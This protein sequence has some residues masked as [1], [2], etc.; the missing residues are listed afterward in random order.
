MP[1][2]SAAGLGDAPDGT[3]LVGGDFGLYQLRGSRFEKLKGNFK[4]VSW[5]QGIQAD[6][7]GHTYIGTDTGLVVL[8]A[9]ADKSGF[10]VQAIPQPVSVTRTGAFGVLVDG[11]TVWYGCGLELCRINSQGTTVLGRQ[12][13]LPEY[14]CSTIQKDGD[15]NLWLRKGKLGV[16]E[17]PAGQTKFR[18]P[19]SPVLVEAFGGIAS[20]DADGR[21]LLPSAEGLLIRDKDGWQKV[22]RSVGL[23]G[24]VYSVLEDRQHSLWIGLAG[25]GLVQWRGYR[26]W[27][28]YSTASGLGNDLVYEVLARPDGSMWAGTEGGLYVGRQRDLKMVWSRIASF[29]ESAVHSLQLAPDGDLWV[30]TEARGAARM[31]SLDHSV[32]WFGEKQGLIGALLH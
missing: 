23:R 9:I 13:G 29:G 22:D 30:G 20:T 24:P 18:R 16:F 28:T 8:S 3:L 21:I 26:E 1:Y 17:L 32:T 7:K 25:R 27:T 15:G 31:R 11:D 14:A 10:Q 12:A 2:A 4:T 19:D 6:G 5:A